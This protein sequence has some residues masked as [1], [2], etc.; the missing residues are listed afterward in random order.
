MLG[1]PALLLALAGA[2]A[3]RKGALL[4]AGACALAL[5]STGTALGIDRVLFAPVPLS[6]IFRF[7]E[8]LTAP[9]SLLFALAAALGA[10]LALAG[11]RRAAFRLAAAAVVLAALA[12]GLAFLIGRN[13][14]LLAQDFAAYGKTHRL[15]FSIAFWRETHA[16]L[17]DCAGLA[18]TLGAVALWRWRR[19]L[20]AAS[21]G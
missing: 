15:L 21:T 1:A 18:A 6:G 7:A 13:A 5:A 8:K 10:D 11:T 4:F 16:G 3:R 2:F 14:P 19:Q 12:A 17:I 9:A 20:P